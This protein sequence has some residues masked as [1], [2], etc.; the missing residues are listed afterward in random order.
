VLTVLSFFMNWACRFSYPPF[1][2]VKYKFNL[3]SVDSVVSL[4]YL[5]KWQYNAF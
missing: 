1:S 4:F 2:T 3:D 5:Q